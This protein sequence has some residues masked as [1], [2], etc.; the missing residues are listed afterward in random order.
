MHEDQ[1]NQ[2][3]KIQVSAFSASG[4]ANE[5]KRSNSGAS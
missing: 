4:N 2:R 1:Q 3:T 5:K